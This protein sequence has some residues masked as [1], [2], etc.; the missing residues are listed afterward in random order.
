MGSVNREI[1]FETNKFL[2]TRNVAFG[3][4]HRC[5]FGVWLEGRKKEI[6]EVNTPQNNA[7]LQVYTA[8]QFGSDGYCSYVIN[9]VLC[10]T[11]FLKWII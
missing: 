2:K 11:I 4:Q 10:V 9:S 6:K 5:S 3:M 8:G 7:I 1:I